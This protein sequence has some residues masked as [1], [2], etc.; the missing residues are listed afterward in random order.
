MHPILTMALDAVGIPYKARFSIEEVA[1]VLA[2]RR[3]QVVD[4]LKKGRLRGIKSSPSRWRWIYADD[5][6][7]YLAAI[8]GTWEKTVSLTGPDASIDSAHIGTSPSAPSGAPPQNGNKYGDSD[9]EQKA[10]KAFVKWMGNLPV[11]DYLKKTIDEHT[12]TA[13]YYS[14]TKAETPDK[15]PIFLHLLREATKADDVI[16]REVGTDDFGRAV[17]RGT[18]LPTMIDLFHDTEDILPPIPVTAN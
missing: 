10:A 11:L 8:N 12:L 4:L 14:K 6:G 16:M 7:A 17:F 2:I 9:Y 13:F 1:E 3:E 18:D 5:L 15:A